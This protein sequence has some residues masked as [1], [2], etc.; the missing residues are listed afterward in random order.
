MFLHEYLDVFL[1]LAQAFAFI[2]IPGAAL[3]DDIHGRAQV[4][5]SAFAG[6]PRAVHD[7]E[8]AVFERRCHFIL[9]DFD[10][11]PVADDVATGF[12]GFALADFHADR[13]VELQGPAACRRFGIAEHDADIFHAAG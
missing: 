11:R 9:D 10:P 5:D 3:F 4:E 7:V 2:R 13:R 6:N 8:F 12:D 1:A